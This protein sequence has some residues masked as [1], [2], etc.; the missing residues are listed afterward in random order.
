MVCGQFAGKPRI[1]SC[2]GQFHVI[3][4]AKE[5]NIRKLEGLGYQL[6]DAIPFDVKTGIAALTTGDRQTALRAC[7]YAVDVIITAKG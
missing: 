3:V 2:R 6:Q 4:P 5:V 7:P 1:V